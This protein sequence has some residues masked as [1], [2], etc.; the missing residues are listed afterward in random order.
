MQ[1]WVWSGQAGIVLGSITF[2][3][4]FIPIL[5]WQYRTYGRWSPMRMLGAAATSIYIT[6][7]ATYTWMPL[8]PRS[9]EWCALN[10]IDTIN[11][12]PFAFMDD[13][14]QVVAEVGLRQALRNVVVLQVVFNVVLFVPWGIIVRRF[15]HRGFIITV[16][17]GFAASVFVEATQATGLWGVY[18]CAYRWADIDDVIMNTAGTFGGAII[19]PIVLFWMPRG[20]TLAATRMQPRAITSWRRYGSMLI[21][22]G[23]LIAFTIGAIVSVRMALLLFDLPLES[24]L[25]SVALTAV[26]LGTA[27]FFVYVPALAG[28]GNVG[29]QV[30]WLAPRWRDEL[31][32]YQPGTTSQRLARASVIGIPYLAF[33]L[34]RNETYAIV[35]LGIGFLSAILVPFTRTRKSLSGLLLGNDLIDSRDREVPVSGLPRDGKEV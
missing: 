25:E 30:V 33:A 16:L 31:G 24:N 23:A 29:M 26:A 34:T 4:A 19:A 14:R 28:N 10:G 1:T 8:P 7:I 11:L 9:A 15:F 32:E 5:I 12:T 17:S 20:A 27:L 18:E 21:T 3:L 22:G 13:V 35:F 2:L 6:A